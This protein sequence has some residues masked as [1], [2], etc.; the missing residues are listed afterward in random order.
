MTRRRNDMTNQKRYPVYVRG[1]RP[2]DK[3]S[4]IYVPIF[5]EIEEARLFIEG[6]I[7]D[8]EFNREGKVITF[9]CGFK[10]EITCE[11]MDR[12]MN[13]PL[14]GL[15]LPLK[16][17]GPS[18]RFKYGEWEEKHA[19]PVEEKAKPSKPKP[20]SD[21][22]SKPKKAKASIPEGYITVTKLCEGTDV[23]PTHARAALR[24]SGTNKPDHGW[25]F[26]PKD[27]PA[28]KKIIGV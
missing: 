8:K 7:A 1:H 13:T 5:T 9:D 10:V 15:I 16:Y 6:M 2:P 14:T 19:K 28:I 17:R 24:A 12:V 23:L 3:D 25:A 27:L 22:S 21:K 11:A 20:S 26:G 4:R 18:V